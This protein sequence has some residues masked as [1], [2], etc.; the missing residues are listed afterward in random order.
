M[1][2]FV[3][4]NDHVWSFRLNLLLSQSSLIY[5]TCATR[6]IRMQHKCNLSDTSEPQVWHECDVSETRT[7]RVWHELYTND[8]SATRVEIFDFHSNTSKNIFSHPY[9]YYM[10]SARF[11]GEEQFHSKNYLLE[12][13]GKMRLK[14]APQKL[15]F[16]IAKAISKSYALDCSDKCPCTFPHS[17]A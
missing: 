4:T 14:S 10:V 17:Y 1:L 8:T 3:I 6:M 9:N 7:T 11:L 16:L 2:N 12:P 13:H 5:N 15:N